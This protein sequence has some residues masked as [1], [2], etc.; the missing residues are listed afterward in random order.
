LLDH[1]LPK[2]ISVATR[3][4]TAADFQTTVENNDIVLVDFWAEWCGPCRMFAPIYDEVSEQHTDVVFGKVDTEAEQQLAGAF[5]IR[6][7]PTLMAFRDGI[8]VF[9]QAGALPA[10]ALEDLLSQIRDLDMDA[11][12][13]Q[14]AAQA[15]S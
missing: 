6:S 11:V 4:L 13:E 8:M 10:A 3:D 1:S 7:I 14:L 5:G 9:S 12:R 2:D 15:A